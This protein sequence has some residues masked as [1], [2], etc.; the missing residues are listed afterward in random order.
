[1]MRS[2]KAQGKA[3]VWCDSKNIKHFWGWQRFTSWRTEDTRGTRTSVEFLF[4]VLHISRHVMLSNT[5]NCFRTYKNLSYWI[6]LLCCIFNKKNPKCIW[7]G[8]SLWHRGDT[9][10]CNFLLKLQGGTGG[11]AG[12]CCWFRV[13]EQPSWFLLL[14]MPVSKHSVIIINHPKRPV[15]RSQPKNP[16]RHPERCFKSRRVDVSC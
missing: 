16:H 4:Y 10:R 1:M 13:S 9:A 11:R 8:A 15:C 6:F 5:L 12:K 14:N 3:E 2:S 7:C